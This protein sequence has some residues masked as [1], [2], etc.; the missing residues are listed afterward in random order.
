VSTSMRQ[1]AAEMLRADAARIQRIVDGEAPDLGVRA[2]GP[3][4][5]RHLTWAAEA[6]ESDP[7]K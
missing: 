4:L 6:L 5:V 1:Q 7:P 3:E 2:M